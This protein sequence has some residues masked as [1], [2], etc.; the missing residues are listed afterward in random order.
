[1]FDWTIMASVDISIKTIS[2]CYDTSY[3][4]DFYKE[5][6]HLTASKCLFALIDYGYGYERQTSL[7]PDLFIVGMLTGK[8]R[9]NHE[10]DLEPI[11]KPL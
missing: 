5:L 2:F 8:P 1:M 11:P 9:I 4:S 7:G 10:D 6:D 3:S